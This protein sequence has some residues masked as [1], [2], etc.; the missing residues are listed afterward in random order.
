MNTGV[1]REC[2]DGNEVSTNVVGISGNCL[3]FG[4]DGNFDNNDGGTGNDFT[5]GAGFDGDA[6]GFTEVLSGEEEGE[7]DEEEDDDEGEELLVSVASPKL[8]EPEAEAEAKAEAE[9][10]EGGETVD[11]AGELLL[12]APITEDD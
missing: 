3:L 1:G 2:D 8:E 4:G 11:P 7:E 6:V 12:H 5:A 9:A 10:D